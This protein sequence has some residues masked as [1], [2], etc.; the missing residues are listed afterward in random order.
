MKKRVVG[1]TEF[2][3]YH[4]VIADLTASS[5][6]TGWNSQRNSQSEQSGRLRMYSCS[7]LPGVN[8]TQVD[9]RYHRFLQVIY[10]KTCVCWIRL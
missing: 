9:A 4:Y 2:L 3:W 5:K 10:I 7:E 1:R 8:T 6:N